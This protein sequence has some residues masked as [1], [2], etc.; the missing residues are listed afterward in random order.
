[1]SI[2]YRIT[3]PDL[4]PIELIGFTD[5]DDY[6]AYK[7]IPT[8]DGETRPYFNFEE[9]RSHIQQRR[10]AMGYDPIP[11]LQRIIENYLYR[12]KIVPKSMFHKD[13]EVD[14]TLIKDINTG[15]SLAMSFSRAAMSGKFGIGAAGWVNR[16]EANRRA[17]ICA[18]CPN[19][20]D[21][22]KN[23]ALRARN[24]I[25]ALF[26][27]L[28]TTDYDDKL[29]DC[30]VCECPNDQKVHYSESIIRDVTDA[31]PE[32]FP[33]RFI[34]IDNKKHRCWVREILSERSD[35]K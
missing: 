17:S 30:G 16:V 9:L 26:T 35:K 11:Q 2:L 23:L 3:N 31:D 19:N 13:F 5:P 20:V 22:Q 4:F 34:G 32:E 1:M 6:F 21:L 12:L 33:D 29:L 25:A 28:R 8:E 18:Q 27:P 15:A 10:A 7:G 24:R 14:R